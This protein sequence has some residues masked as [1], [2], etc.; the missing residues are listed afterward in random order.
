MDDETL[1]SPMDAVLRSYQQDISLLM[2]DR[3]ILPQPLAAEDPIYE[4]TA[5]VKELQASVDRVESL[6][7]RVVAAVAQSLGLAKK[8]LETE[9]KLVNTPLLTSISEQK[10]A[11]TAFGQQLEMLGKR[12]DRSGAVVSPQQWQFGTILGLFFISVLIQGGSAYLSKDAALLQTPNGQI[13]KRIIEL[14]PNLLGLCKEKLS[15]K[16]R[17]QVEK[18]DVA[19]GFCVSVLY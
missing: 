19:K 17:K 8:E 5:M 16:Q 12:L 1:V 4:V 9:F 14:N 10:G 18:G 2:Q 6:K 11:F 13:G 15:N 7:D 3:P